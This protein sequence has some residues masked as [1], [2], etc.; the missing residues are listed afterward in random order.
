MKKEM[1]CFVLCCMFIDCKQ[2]VLQNHIQINI[3]NEQTTH[4]SVRKTF[5]SI[6]LCSYS[7]MV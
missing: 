7:I 5:I 1:Y 4:K 2:A 6:V 3:L